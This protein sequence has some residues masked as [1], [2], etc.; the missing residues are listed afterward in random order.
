[1]YRVLVPV[2]TNEK[3]AGKQVEYLKSRPAPPEQVT[4]IVLHVHWRDSQPP[5]SSEGFEAVDAAVTAAD[6]LEDAGI[7]VERVSRRG[8]LSRQILTC[9]EEYDVDEIV[10]GARERAGTAKGLTGSTSKTL[11]TDS[12]L[13]VVVTA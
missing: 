13:P 1:M 11:L 12:D 9:A 4:A 3:R 6:R 2:D 7:S 8:T 10:V 5:E